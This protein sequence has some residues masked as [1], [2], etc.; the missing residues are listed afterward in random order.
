VGNGGVVDERPH[1]LDSSGF[2]LFTA[3]RTVNPATDRAGD[4]EGTR[5]G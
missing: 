2:N 3:C 1:G 4:P 5:P